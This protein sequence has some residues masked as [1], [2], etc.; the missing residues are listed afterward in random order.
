MFILTKKGIVKA[1]NKCKQTHYFSHVNTVWRL[2]G[3]HKHTNNLS[4]GI[5]AVHQQQ[6][7]RPGITSLYRLCWNN[8]WIYV[9]YEI[10]G[11][12]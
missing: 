2:R 4:G 7:F 6:M 12:I 5:S 8:G 3:V 10:M 9:K 1:P 11:G